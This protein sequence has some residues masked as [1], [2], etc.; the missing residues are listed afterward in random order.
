MGSAS[1]YSRLTPS[2][3][4]A[5]LGR[6]CRTQV[7]ATVNF[8]HSGPRINSARSLEL[9]RGKTD[10]KVQLCQSTL[11]IDLGLRC[12]K[13]WPITTYIWIESLSAVASFLMFVS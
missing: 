1:E 7:P 11:I 10:D 3:G 2:T 9:P 8:S 12:V 4:I 13:K 5:S 6:R